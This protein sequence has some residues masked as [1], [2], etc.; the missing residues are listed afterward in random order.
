VCAVL[1]LLNSCALTGLF[2]EKDYQQPQL[3]I[4]VAA[5]FLPVEIRSC[6]VVRADGSCLAQPGW[7]LRKTESGLLYRALQHGSSPGRCGTN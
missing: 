5:F 3:S 2:G 6:P 7:M 4:M 1:K